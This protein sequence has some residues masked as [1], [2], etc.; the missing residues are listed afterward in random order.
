MNFIPAR[1]INQHVFD[2]KVGMDVF[3]F[4]DGGQF[5]PQLIGMG[6]IGGEIGKFTRKG[7]GHDPASHGR[8]I[9]GEISEIHQQT[10]FGR[11][12]VDL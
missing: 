9:G 12:A 5:S 10:F 4:D 6:D 8:G 3:G 7:A 2:Q 11:L 1:Q